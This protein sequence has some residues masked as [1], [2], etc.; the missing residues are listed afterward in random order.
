M[1]TRVENRETEDRLMGH[2]DEHGHHQQVPPHA[3]A[4]KTVAFDTTSLNATT[5]R[6]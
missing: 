5:V 6:H 4:V 3:G 2:S 1:N